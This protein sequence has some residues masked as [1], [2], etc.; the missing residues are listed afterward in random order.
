MFNRIQIIYGDPKMTLAP[1]GS[2]VMILLQHPIVILAPLG[3]LVWIVDSNPI[4]T[5][6]LYRVQ[7][8]SLKVTPLCPL[9]L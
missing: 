3:S 4:A 7:Y 5:L 6:P 8:R 9:P 1:L 2:T